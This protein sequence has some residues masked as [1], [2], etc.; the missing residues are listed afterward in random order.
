MLSPAHLLYLATR[1]GAEVMGVSA[2]TGDFTPGKSADLV[3]LQP[4]EGSPLA[5]AVAHA[6]S[7]ESLLAALITQAGADSIVEVRVRGRVIP[8]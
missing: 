4:P 5:A 3:R 7:P 2:Q 1:A 6:E 8:Q